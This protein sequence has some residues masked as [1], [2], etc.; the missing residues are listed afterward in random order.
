[1]KSDVSGRIDVISNYDDVS[2]CPQEV[3]K[4]TVLH[5][6]MFGLILSNSQSIGGFCLNPEFGLTICKNKTLVYLPKR[7]K[8]ILVDVKDLKPVQS[9]TY[10]CFYQ[11]SNWKITFYT[12]RSQKNINLS[13]S[14]K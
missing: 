7:P 12:G 14:S 9:V 6:R 10:L 13:F 2:T 11:F 4:E 1:M 3:P 5:L 8:V